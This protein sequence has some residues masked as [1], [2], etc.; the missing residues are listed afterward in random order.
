MLTTALSLQ[1]QR[2]T[3]EILIDLETRGLIKRL[4]PTDLI[5]ANPQYD[6]VDTIYSSSPG[7]GAHRLICI[8]KNQTRIALTVH[9]ENEEVIFLNSGSTSFKPLYLIISLVSLD[10]LLEKIQNETL[11]SDDILALE[12]DFNDLHTQVFT[13]LKDTPHCEI[14]VPGSNPAPIF[15]VTESADIQMHSVDMGAISLQLQL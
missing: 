5:Q 8:R 7:S 6:A 12:V 11:S 3:H 10:A 13:I 2:L 14:T 1:P 15:Y 9:S 4:C